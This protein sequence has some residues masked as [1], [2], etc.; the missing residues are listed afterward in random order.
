[1][2]KLKMARNQLEALYR[3]NIPKNIYVQH[4]DLQ[5]GVSSNDIYTIKGFKKMPVW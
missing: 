2:A 3:Q 1:M 5:I 4:N